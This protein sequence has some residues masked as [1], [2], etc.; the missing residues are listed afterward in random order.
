MIDEKEPE[1][2]AKF[3]C[4]FCNFK[5]S[6]QSAYNRHILTPKHKNIESSFNKEPKQPNLFLCV[7][8]K[9]YKH[10]QTLHAHKNKCSFKPLQPTK[11]ENDPELKDLILKLLTDNN[12]V[13]QKNVAE[14]KKD[15][16][17]FK[18]EIIDLIPIIGNNNN[19]TN[20]NNNNNNKTKFN[21]KIF[22]N[23]TCKEAIS[24]SEFIE[25]F[26]VTMQNILL[27]KDKGLVESVTQAFIENIN[28][29]SLTERPIHCT[30]KKR[31]RLYLKNDK[32][33]FDQDNTQIKAV[34]RK[35]N[36]KQLQ[37]TEMWTD[38]NPDFMTEDK[39]QDEFV[40]LIGNCTTSFEGREDKIIRNIC[41][42][43]YLNEK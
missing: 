31:E 3:V 41:Q 10:K 21:L 33:E 18:K 24:M 42:H 20:A 38:A 9:E 23:E 11:E 27:L 5:C 35:L 25:R 17:D 6:K 8:G 26:E 37:R 29:L 7:C 22:L 40:K 2:A 36:H 39:L 14:L 28:K 43:I 4:E 34:L 1:N 15:N 13:I 32:W 12:T 19:N 30:D 16:A